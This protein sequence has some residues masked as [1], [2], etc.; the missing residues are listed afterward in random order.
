[1]NPNDRRYT[2][3]STLAMCK[4]LTGIRSYALD[5]AAEENHHCADHY[6][7]AKDNGLVSGWY[8]DVWC[9]PPW[10]EIPEWIECAW[11]WLARSS[12]V[13]SVSMLLPANRTDQ[14][15]W[16]TH[17]EQDRDI[18][19]CLRTHFL[20]GRIKYGT[21]SDP[22]AKKQGS[23]AFGSVLLVWRQP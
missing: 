18:G 15:W 7:T 1:M 10:S 5:V 3:P 4:R 12:F 13:D 14:A 23:P 17:V 6:Y 9:N 11:D 19:A 16:Q 8:G 2:L 20:P 22:L 21:P